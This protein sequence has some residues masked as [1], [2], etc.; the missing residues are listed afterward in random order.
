MTSGAN[1]GQVFAL[2][3]GELIIGREEGSEIQ[4]ADLRVS[5]NHAVLRVHGTQVTIEDLRSTN[6]TKVNGVAIERQ[7][8]LVPGDELNLGGV[9]LVLNDAEGA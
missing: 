3:P 1:A 6:G 2:H 5:H 7:I 9:Q 4:L 8:P